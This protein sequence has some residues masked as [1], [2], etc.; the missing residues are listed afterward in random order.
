MRLAVLV[1]MVLLAARPASADDIVTETGVIEGVAVDH[2]FQPLPSVTVRIVGE[3]LV[4]TLHA[5]AAGEIRVNGL[6][7]GRYRIEVE[8][9][10]FSHRSIARPDSIVLD[11][12]RFICVLPL[13]PRLIALNGGSSERV[14]R[15]L[16]RPRRSCSEIMDENHRLT[17]AARADAL[18][19]EL[20]RT[21]RPFIDTHSTTLGARFGRR[22]IFGTE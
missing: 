5:T 2:L 8:R 9:G 17:M 11:K 15:E 12:E 13:P 20:A 1:F 4:M 14:R 16:G 22:E 18:N 10:G 7:P 6:P 19:R 21:S 3:A